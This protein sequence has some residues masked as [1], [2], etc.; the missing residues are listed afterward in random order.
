MKL[1]FAGVIYVVDIAADALAVEGDKDTCE[2]V[3][4]LS[5]CT[6]V[7]VALIANVTVPV[8]FPLP[9][10]TSFSFW[11]ISLR[12]SLSNLSNNRT[13]FTTFRLDSV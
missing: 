4:D 13:I 3:E 5:S 12:C 7:L 9:P 6:T 10:M 8:L 2:L 11:A 1:P